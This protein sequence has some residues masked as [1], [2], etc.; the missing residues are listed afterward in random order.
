VKAAVLPAI[1]VNAY[2]RPT[3]LARLLNSLDQ[4]VYP[5]ATEVPLI[6]SID[7]GGDPTVR[8][9]AENFAW[10]RGP[11]EVIVQAPH[12]GLVQHFFACGDLTQRYE[13]I[14]YL[15]DDLT[16]SPVFYAYAQQALS[17]YRED[18]RIAGLSLFGLWFNGYT[19]QPFTPLP[20]GSDAFFV[21]VPYTQG[22][23]FTAAQ[24]AR[25]AAWRH[26]LLADAAPLVPLHA[27]WLRFDREDW[28]PL[29]ARFV[30]TTDRYFAFPRVSHTTGWG[31]AGTHFAQASRFFQVPLQRSKTGYDF[32]TWDEADAVYDSFF[33]LQPDRL[34]RLTDQLRGCNYTVDLYATKS[35]ANLRA[36]YVLTSRRCR[37]PIVSF[38]KT[39]WPIEMNV[40][41]RVPGAEICLCRL[42]DVRWDRLAQ[43]QLWHSNTEYFARGRL[44]RLTTAL[45]LIAA[46]MLKRFQA[47]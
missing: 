35:R 25:F 33:E 44:P 16:V 47:R 12:L 36:E 41:E 22:L 17:F 2:Q 28:F 32:K 10:P 15:E 6:I 42:Q 19:Q 26:S 4:A 21:Q 39:A 9:L 24:W 23:A 11:K 46:R 30:I 3:A 5:V 27:A 37:D 8:T 38:G 1:V 20:D 13:A 34:N 43:L 7:H 45:K 18:D 14:V 31:D 29:L 40:V